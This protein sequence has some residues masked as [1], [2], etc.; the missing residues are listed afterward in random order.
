LIVFPG[1]SAV[2]LAAGSS[3][4][5]GSPKQLMRLGK[6]PLLEHVLAN[7]RAANVAEII[8]VL[9]FAADQIQQKISTQGLVIVTN[10]DYQQGIMAEIV[11]ERKRQNS[12][13]ETRSVA[14]P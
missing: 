14:E 2:I 6:K 4:R 7:I 8:L 11:L 9:G 10:Q 1:I 12:A 13:T 3:Q 5:M